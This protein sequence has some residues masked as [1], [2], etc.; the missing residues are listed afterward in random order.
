MKQMMDALVLGTAI[1]L[2]GAAGAG[3]EWWAVPAMSGVA[4]MPDAVPTDGV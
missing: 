3:V 4:R 1:A 2:A